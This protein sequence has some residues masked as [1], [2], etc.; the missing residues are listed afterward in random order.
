MGSNG[1]T[2][3]GSRYCACSVATAG[4]PGD[5]SPGGL[6]G[7]E[8][9]SYSSLNPESLVYDSG[10]EQWLPWSVAG[11]Y[12]RPQSDDEANESEPQERGSSLEASSSSG[13]ASQESGAEPT[14]VPVASQQAAST[15]LG[16]ISHV[17]AADR[18][19]WLA[20]GRQPGVV[21]EAVESA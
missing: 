3:S 20:A 17:G 6:L 14:R 15:Q 18:A 19:S 7:G 11:E 16:A 13:G 2:Q 21:L 5:S 9:D 4:T 12:L 1:A 10:A 8:D